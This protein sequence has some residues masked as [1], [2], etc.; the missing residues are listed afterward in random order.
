MK[1]QRFV[2]MVAP[3]STKLTSKIDVTTIQE[4]NPEGNSI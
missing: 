3:N 1:A 4:E 2:S